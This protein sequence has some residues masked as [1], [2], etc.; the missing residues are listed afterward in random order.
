MLAQEISSFL[1][2]GFVVGM[3]FLSNY[4]LHRLEVK[5]L[6]V[7]NEVREKIKR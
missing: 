6:L 1:I 7:H 2:F 5:P 4:F 3:G